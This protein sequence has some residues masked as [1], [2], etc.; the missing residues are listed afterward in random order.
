MTDKDEA[1][2]IYKDS[3]K[4]PIPTYMEFLLNHARADR[5]LLDAA[6]DMCGGAMLN[7]TLGADTHSELGITTAIELQERGVKIMLYVEMKGRADFHSM[8]DAVPL[9]ERMAVLASER[10]KPTAVMFHWEESKEFKSPPAREAMEALIFAAKTEFPECEHVMAYGY[11]EFRADPQAA[12]WH[13]PYKCEL[14]LNACTATLYCREPTT[15]DY[16]LGQ[17]RSASVAEPYMQMGSPVPVYAYT[18]FGYYRT[19][20]KDGDS[21]WSFDKFAQ[22]PL[23]AWHMQGKRFAYWGGKP[24]GIKVVGIIPFKG[25]QSEQ[26][27]ADKA[28]GL[29]AMALGMRGEVMREY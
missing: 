28:R 17:M 29:R 13:N 26:P 27:Q 15:P 16:C 3:P 25:L 1:I 6:T 12:G 7:L 18:S 9:V 8:M 22:R 2:A 4:M 10:V 19:C 11:E 5:D 21:R 20:E 23:E 24:G 14:P